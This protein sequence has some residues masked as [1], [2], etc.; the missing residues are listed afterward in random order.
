MYNNVLIQKRSL[1]RICSTALDAIFGIRIDHQ[2]AIDE[3][4]VTV[5][6]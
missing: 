4:P 1:A 3:S 5:N 6:L 2:Q